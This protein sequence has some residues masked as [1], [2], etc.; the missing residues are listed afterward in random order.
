MVA[1]T[2]LTFADQLAN[3]ARAEA[4][5]GEVSS[6]AAA[7]RALVDEVQRSHP[8]D[9]L[10]APLRQ[11]LGDELE[12][13][14]DLIAPGSSREASVT[15]D[16]VDVLV[17]DDEED[18]LRASVAAVMALGYPCRVA[19]D[20]KDALRAYAER[21]AAIVLSDWCMPGI[22][23]IEL[24]RALKATTPAPYVILATAFH[25]NARVLDAVS[26]GV[27]DF[28]RKPLV[29]DE[30]EV[31]MLAASRLIRA[32]RLVARVQEKVRRR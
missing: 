17:V 19:R 13:L 5:A 11:Q 10:V 14:V 25:D 12:R 20:G 4:P 22:S 9:R 3:P 8:E 6:Q 32:L 21:P 2:A 27:D 28:L 1:K 7:V 31:R 26:G 30:L 29:L 15:E 23:G 24:C 18:S 16:P